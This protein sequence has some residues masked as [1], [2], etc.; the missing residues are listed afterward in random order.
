M[1]MSDVITIFKNLYSEDYEVE[2][3][4]T[5]IQEI[6]WR[7]RVSH[8]ITKQDLKNALTWLIDEYI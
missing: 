4:M 2:D 3:K 8:T 1:I 6:A 7:D 5:A